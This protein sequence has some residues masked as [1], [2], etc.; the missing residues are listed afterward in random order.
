MPVLSS[1]QPTCWTCYIGHS[2]A[3]DGWP[4]S[5]SALSPDE[6]CHAECSD[7]HGGLRDSM[8]RWRAHGEQSPLVPEIIEIQ[9]ARRSAK[10]RQSTV[11]HWVAALLDSRVAP[12]DGSSRRG[13]IGGWPSP[14][15]FWIVAGWASHLARPGVGLGPRE[16]PGPHGRPRSL[17]PRRC[18]RIGPG[19]RL[20]VPHERRRGRVLPP[21]S[22]PSP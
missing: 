7:Q 10:H 3:D 2:D 9:A 12:G 11:D 20:A 6:P 1:T 22:G 17:T 5:R 18:T 8:R 13:V 4:G 21:R 16:R 14:G 19:P 15:D